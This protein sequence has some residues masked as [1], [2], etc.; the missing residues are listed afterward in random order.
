MRFVAVAL[1]IVLAACSRG[2]SEPSGPTRSTP[3]PGVV[4][5]SNPPP[6]GTPVP[7][8][9]SDFRCEVDGAGTYTATGAVTNRSKAVTTFQVTVNV[10]QP[11][12]TPQAAM[13]K[14]LAKVRPG[15]SATFEIVKIPVAADGGT[16]HVQV[17]TTK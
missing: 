4:T 11:S 9:L 6:T 15:G 14:Q 1:L 8:A 12:G 7:E 17:V 10:G 13:T 5:P 16:C 2:S 3:A